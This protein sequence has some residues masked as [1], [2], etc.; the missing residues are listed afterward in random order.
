M[1]NRFFLFPSGDP[2]V[3]KPIVVQEES[4]SVEAL[5]NEFQAV[6]AMVDEVIAN[7]EPWTD[8]DFPP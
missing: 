3:I 4:T 6:K 7:G 2:P 8:N 1:D 5:S